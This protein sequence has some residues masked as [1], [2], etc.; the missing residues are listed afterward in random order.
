MV[1]DNSLMKYIAIVKIVDKTE[2]KAHVP[3]RIDD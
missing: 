3:Y 1:G 2:F